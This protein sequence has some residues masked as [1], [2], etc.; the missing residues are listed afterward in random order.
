MAIYLTE[1][2][3][4]NTNQ[5]IDVRMVVGSQSYYLYKEDIPLSYKF[6]GLRVWDLNTGEIGTPYVWTGTI[7]SSENDIGA[8]V[9]TT[10]GNHN[11][12]VK[13]ED[14][15]TTLSKSSL[16]DNGNSIGLG[17]TAASINCGIDGLH[18]LGNI[19]TNG[20]FDG[21]GSIISDISA[22][23]IT[24]GILSLSLIERI[25]FTPGKKYTLSQLNTGVFWSE[26]ESSVYIS[27]DDTSSSI[28][29]INFTNGLDNKY[30]IKG[31]NNLRYKSSTK[32]LLSSSGSKE[33]P[34]YSF[35][36]STSVG[37]YRTSN[38]ISFTNGGVG[39]VSIFDGGL[40][41]THTDYPQIA[42]HSTTI[43]KSRLLFVN[44]ANNLLFRY[45]STVVDDKI[46]FH[47]SNLFHLRQL[48]I[49]QLETGRNSN[50]ITING[51]GQSI[52]GIYNYNIMNDTTMNTSLSSVYTT[53]DNS[54]KNWSTMVI[55]NGANGGSFQ[56]AGNHAGASASSR[57][58]LV[59]SLDTSV[60]SWSDWSR[61]C[62]NENQSF[63]WSMGKTHSTRD[64]LKSWLESNTPKNI[65]TSFFDTGGNFTNIYN[66]IEYNPS[67]YSLETPTAY[68][69]FGIKQLVRQPRHNI[70]GYIIEYA[71]NSGPSANDIYFCMWKSHEFDPNTM[72]EWSLHDASS[73]SILWTQ[74]STS[75][76]GNYTTPIIAPCD[77]SNATINT[78][79]DNKKFLSFP[80][81]A[82]TYGGFSS[83]RVY[84][85]ELDPVL[86]RT[87]ISIQIYP[88]SVQDI[89]I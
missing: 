17:L 64:I 47:D 70:R 9:P 44:N 30:D 35:I 82:G 46:V 11:Y 65:V 40:S 59:R 68:D 75:G 6:Q 87:Q 50:G 73:A 13:F 80:Q 7:W 29:Y 66:G 36:N 56:I 43:N 10:S 21:D 48:S 79:L 81:G 88:K 32:Q 22:T 42:F 34:S 77:S 18:V 8:T 1:N 16:Y 62:L 61:V 52:G 89:P 24:S 39:I 67:P 25:A 49:N 23:N 3:H 20:R 76:G 71:V 54:K 60:T 2:F 5:P 12:I 86:Q 84:H 45:D 57:E 53:L 33:E 41:I 27:L 28:N 83:I 51:S 58:M 55:G 37:M 26:V 31:S 69:R 85:K 15:S 14:D 63:R 19:K 74:D 72:R 78:F 38:T 4:F